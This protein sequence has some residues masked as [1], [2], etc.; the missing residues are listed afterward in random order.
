MGKTGAGRAVGEI[1]SV[2]SPV[3]MGAPSSAELAYLQNYP[4]GQGFREYANGGS[5]GGSPALLTGGEFIMNAGTVRQHGLGFMGELNRGKMP[6][7]AAGG[8]VGGVVGG[9]V[10]SVNNNVSV[11]VNIDRRGNADAS[12]SPETSTDNTSS[13]NSA[14]DAQKNKDLGVALQTVVLQ[15]IMKQQRPGGLLQGKPYA[16]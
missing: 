15:E 7:M 16:T 4:P 8:P 12:T 11:N 3:Q 10:G 9:G 13:E 14:A 6:G 1:G 2:A 5:V